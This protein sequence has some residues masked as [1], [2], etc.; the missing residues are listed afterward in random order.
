MGIPGYIILGVDPSPDA[1]DLDTV[2][3]DS[4]P[5]GGGVYGGGG[6]VPLH[7]N[8]NVTAPTCKCNREN[9]TAKM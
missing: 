5:N 7:R 6:G 3:S 1:V 8:V 2:D 9:V 4:F